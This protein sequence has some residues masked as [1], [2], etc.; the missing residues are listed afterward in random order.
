V[1]ASGPGC[2]TYPTTC[3]TTSATRSAR[4]CLPATASSTRTWAARSDFPSSSAT[5]LLHFT[6]TLPAH[7][8]LYSGHDY[9]P[10]ERG[11]PLPYTTVA[12]QNERNKHV[13]RGVEEAQFVQRRS[14]R[15]AALGEPKL[16]HQALQFNIRSRSLPEVTEGTLRLRVPVKVSAAMM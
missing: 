6:R 15:D 10:S 5:A 8:R 9:P 13:N 1:A 11:V 12:E 7:F 14:E 16:L 2:C 4:P 3:P